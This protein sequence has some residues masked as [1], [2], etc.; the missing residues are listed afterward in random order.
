MCC[1]IP[2]AVLGM[3]T[4]ALWG[5]SCDSPLPAFGF[6]SGSCLAPLQVCLWELSVRAKCVELNAVS[7]VQG[8][9]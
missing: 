5:Q 8:F 1:C 6:P 4:L 3:M 7:Y 9:S 2:A